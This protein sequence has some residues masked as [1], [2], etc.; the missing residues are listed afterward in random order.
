[1]YKRTHFLVA[2]CA[3]IGSHLANTTYVA[4]QTPPPS[5]NSAANHWAS[6]ARGGDAMHQRLSMGVGKSVIVD[7]PRDASEIFVGNPAVANAVVR[8]ARKLYV[9]G[10]ANGQTT[11]FAMDAAGA[12]IAKIDINIGRDVGELQR[13]LSAAIPDSNIVARTVEE[14]IILTGEVPTAGDAQK[15]MDIAAGFLKVE[16]AGDG[17]DSGLAPSSAGGG[18]SGASAAAMA[19]TPAS[20]SGLSLSVSERMLAQLPMASASARAPPTWMRLSD[21]ASA[22]SWHVRPRSA[23]RA[24]ELLSTAPA[25]WPAAPGS[26]RT[27]EKRSLRLALVAR[28]AVA[29]ASAPQSLSSLP[30]TSSS[31]SAG[32]TGSSCRSGPA[33]RPKQLAAMSAQAGCGSG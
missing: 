26:V 2:S 3:L 31:V 33:A 28:S 4:A 5:R 13:I 16:G 19:A 22:R 12:Q 18:A 15:A 30:E 25:I 10:M 17:A 23:A 27:Y 11:I 7:L 21:S 9:I 14:A 32:Y 20:L 6:L 1:M 29:I 8:S 24:R